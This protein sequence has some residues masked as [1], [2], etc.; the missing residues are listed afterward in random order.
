MKQNPYMQGYQ[1]WATKGVN[2]NPYPAESDDHSQYENGNYDARADDAE[3]YR[4]MG[5]D[6]GV[7]Q[8]IRA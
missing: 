8:T 4:M 2:N 7:L 6:Q 5:A 3:A 1:D